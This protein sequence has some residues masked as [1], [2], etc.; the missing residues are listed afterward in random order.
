M[1]EIPLLILFLLLSGFFSGAEIAL[2]SLSAEKIKALRNGTT[3]PRILRAI[4]SIERLKEEPQK[5]LVTIL[6]GNNVVNVASSALATVIATRLAENYGLEGHTALVLGGVTGIMT[7]A[8]LV[9]GEIT[10]K[11]L[12]HANALRF[13]LVAAP[14]IG[15][16]QALL[17][18]IVWPLSRL[19]DSITGDSQTT[20]SLSED[21]IKAA[22][23]LAEK[24]GT[25][26]TFE[27]E[28]SERIFEL[29]EHTVESVMTPRSKL[30]LLEDTTPIKEAVEQISEEG[31]SRVPIYHADP[32]QITGILTVRGILDKMHEKNFSH[33]KVA[34]IPCIKP[35]KVPMTMKV[36]SL[37]R[38]LLSEK[39]HM[40][41]VYDEHGGL[42]GLI[43][44]ED[45]MEEVFGEIEDEED[46]QEYFV[47]RI[48]ERSFLCSGDTELE[49]LENSLIIEGFLTSETRLPWPVEAENDTLGY[50]ILEKLE[51]FPELGEVITLP[52]TEVGFEIKVSKLMEESNGKIEEV[53]VTV[54]PG[55]GVE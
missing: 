30:F 52:G 49:Q 25:I 50:L 22:L 20:S 15:F 19:V 7:L 51:R 11:T 3:S 4:R 9:F 54:L 28:W 37:L 10:P 8:L 18:P 42:I 17:L 14:I 12:A 31:F 24:E 23:E 47:R 5:L 1:D 13:S 48:G 36:D 6:I 34:N 46:E 16:L 55:E 21:E 29:S 40:A 38:Q 33:M 39:T 45:I 44:L 35:F 32:D 26:E 43:T 41:L 27:K 2:F 53:E